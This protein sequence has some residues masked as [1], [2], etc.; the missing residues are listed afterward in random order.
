LRSSCWVVIDR[1]VGRLPVRGFLI[2][3]V[4]TAQVFRV[5]GRAGFSPSPAF[6]RK[7]LFG[8]ALGPMPI[9]RPIPRSESRQL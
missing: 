4:E 3:V 6:G 8:E 9:L 1:T 5:P 7:L 2:L